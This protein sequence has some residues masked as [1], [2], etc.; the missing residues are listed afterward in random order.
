MTNDLNAINRLKTI[1]NEWW[2]EMAQVPWRQM[3]R[4]LRWRFR[5]AR[6]GVSASSLTFTTLLALVPLLAVGLALFTA[7]PVFGKFQD[8]LQRWLVDSLVPDSIAR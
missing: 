5:E 7:F 6:L 8:T 2:D 1:W 4:H 3:A